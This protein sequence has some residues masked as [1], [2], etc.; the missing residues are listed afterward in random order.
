LIVTLNEHEEVPQEFVAVHVTVD[1]PVGNDEPEL[2]KHCTEAE[3]VP[4]AVGSI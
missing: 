4:V 3:G 2:G 1:V